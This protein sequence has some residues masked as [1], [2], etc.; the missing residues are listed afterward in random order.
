LNILAI[1]DSIADRAE[2]IAVLLTLKP[3]V[4]ADKIHRD[5]NNFL[6]KNIET[7]KGARR[8]IKELH[9]LLESSFVGIEAEKVRT[10]VEDVASKEHEAD[11]IQQ[12]LLKSLFQMEEE[13]SYATF[14]LWQK[15]FASLASI[16]NLSEN[17][18]YCIRMTLDVK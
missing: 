3:L 5:F 10:M 7:F 9:E 1:Q 16:S 17:L 4:M 14:F 8:I 2:D 12:K 6:E 13:M 15:I 11:L 18:A